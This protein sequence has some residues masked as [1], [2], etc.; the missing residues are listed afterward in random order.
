[1]LF[2]LVKSLSLQLGFREA[3]PAQMADMLRVLIPLRNDH[4]PTF[5]L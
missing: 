5:T 2:L 3:I 4:Q 1:M